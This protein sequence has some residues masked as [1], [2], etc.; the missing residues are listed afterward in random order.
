MSDRVGRKKMF[1]LGC[2]A[3]VFTFLGML[4]LKTLPSHYLL[5]FSL[6][7]SQPV[8][9]MIA[10]THLIEFLPDRESRVS[11]AFMCLDG[12]IYFV[13]P[14]FFK[15]LSKNLEIVMILAF[16]M[17]LIA[18]IGFVFIKVPESLKYL[19][20]SGQLDIFW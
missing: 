2:L 20:N 12:L 6:G 10:Y 5:I 15:N 14:L 9:S 18:F 1:M 3:Q 8:K 13:S 4:S 17:N 11:G 7:L 19:I 16:V